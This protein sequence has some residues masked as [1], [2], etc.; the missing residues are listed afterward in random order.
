MTRF[1]RVAVTVAG[2]CAGTLA[3]GSLAAWADDSSLGQPVVMEHS[4]PAD[5]TLVLDMNVGELKIVPSPQA[6]HLRLEVRGDSK[7][8]AKMVASWVKR[9]DVSADR[10]S[11]EVNAP[12]HDH[13]NNCSSA[14]ATLYLPAHT[15]LK[16][17]LDVGDL[18]IQGIRGNKEVQVR[19]GDLRIGYEDPDEYAH[20][21]TTT[22]IGDVNDPLQSGDAHGFLGKS[23]DFTRQGKYHLRA[24]VWI[25]DLSLFDEGKS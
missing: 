13:C 12:S 7:F 10:A 24:S 14:S 23:E 22:H 18:N 5:G 25:G 2:I 9:F 16:V 21:E 20:V 3:Q 17:K 11:I 8:D 6:D 1:W 19:I 15:A 4:L